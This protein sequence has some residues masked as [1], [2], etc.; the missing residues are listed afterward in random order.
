MHNVVKNL[1]VFAT[2]K[3][4]FSFWHRLK[5]L[6]FSVSLLVVFQSQSWQYLYLNFFHIWTR[7]G[8]GGA[9]VLVKLP[10]RGV[11]LIRLIVGQGPTALAV[12]AGG[13][14]L[15]NFSLIYRFSLLSPDT[16]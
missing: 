8:R 15:D 13:D 9:M 14:D 12:G 2:L 10:V 1:F 11:I 5:A 7:G 6:C 4:L 16:D 3:L